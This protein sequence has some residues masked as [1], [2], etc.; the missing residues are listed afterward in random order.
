[1]ARSWDL[2]APWFEDGLGRPLA[3]RRAALPNAG[4]VGAAY[5]AATGRAAGAAR[6]QSTSAE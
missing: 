1:M 3:V 5:H 4:L 6:R 2:F